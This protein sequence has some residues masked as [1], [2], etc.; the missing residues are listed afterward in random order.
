MSFLKSRLEKMRKQTGEPARTPTMS[1]ASKWLHK[2]HTWCNI[3]PK[4]MLESCSLSR[5]WC[6]QCWQ[7]NWH[8]MLHLN[9]RKKLN[10]IL[11]HCSKYIWTMKFYT[12]IRKLF[13]GGGDRQRESH[14]EREK[15]RKQKRMA[16]PWFATIWG[17]WIKPRKKRSPVEDFNPQDNDR[18]SAYDV[19]TCSKLKPIICL[20]CNIFLWSQHRFNKISSFIR[21]PCC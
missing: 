5:K 15:C 11:S 21:E 12:C 19:K 2:L 1:L 14:R 17:M 3:A 7:L 18:P 20:L 9:F 13:R 4:T 10:P 8:L 16:H 6:L